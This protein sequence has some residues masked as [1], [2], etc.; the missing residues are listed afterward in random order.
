MVSSII[1]ISFFFSVCLS[2]FPFLLTSSLLIQ[3]LKIALESLIQ[4][5]QYLYKP[6]SKALKGQRESILVWFI[7]AARSFQCPPLPTSPFP[8][9]TLPGLPFSNTSA[10]VSSLQTQMKALSSVPS[11]LRADSTT[12]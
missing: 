12:V 8:T 2:L 4:A 10:T 9:S 3:F 5:A 11:F 6:V 1:L 7:T